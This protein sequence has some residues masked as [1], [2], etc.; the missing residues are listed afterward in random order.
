MVGV[1]LPGVV[2][3]AGSGETFVQRVHYRGLERSP[4][5]RIGGFIGVGRICGYRQ[6]IIEVSA[7]DGTQVG[8]S[9]EE[10][11]RRRNRTRCGVWCVARKRGA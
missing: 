9:E 10:G 4:G 3:G 7:R 8:D 5:K 2:L 6:Y 1:N 11:R